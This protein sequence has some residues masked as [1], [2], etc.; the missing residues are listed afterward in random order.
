MILP[1]INVLFLISLASMIHT[2]EPTRKRAQEDVEQVNPK[3]MRSKFTV[4]C[5]SK[6]KT[7][8]GQPIHTCLRC[9]SFKGYHYQVSEHMHNECF[10]VDG[11]FFVSQNAT[12]LVKMPKYL[13]LVKSHSSQEESSRWLCVYCSSRI[14]PEK[15]KKHF[16]LNTTPLM[17]PHIFEGCKEP[18]LIGRN[19]KSFSSIQEQFLREKNEAAFLLVNL[20]ALILKSTE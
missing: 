4:L 18:L 5:Q 12:Q 9:N 17:A 20:E 15:F 11:L 10:P 3:R 1:I 6:G 2:Q 14:S 19:K 7:K 13:D 8:K 16:E